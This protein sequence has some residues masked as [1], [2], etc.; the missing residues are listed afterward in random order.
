LLPLAG[1]AAVDRDVLED[2]DFDK[3]VTI[4][5]NGLSATVT[6]ADAAGVTVAQG[7][8]TSAVAITSSVAGVQYVLSGSSTGGYLQLT[9][10]NRSKVVL[11]GVS[12]VSPNGPA[13]S[14]L[15]S[16]RTFL[17]LADGKSNSLTDSSSYSRP[18]RARSTPAAS[19]SS[20]AAA[21]FRSAASAATASTPTAIFASSAARLPSRRPRR[22]PSIPRAPFSST[23]GI[24]RSRQPATASMPPEA[25]R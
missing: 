24:S 13:V 19:C 22:T 9:S 10:T 16:E 6:G 1:N 12:L 7:S 15:T 2:A 5:Y 11:N 21:V 23:M 25:S 20:P 4:V 8:N 3:T 14:V 18:A 17:V